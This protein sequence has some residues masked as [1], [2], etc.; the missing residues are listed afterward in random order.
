MKL[1]GGVLR[2]DGGDVLLLALCG[3]VLRDDGGGDVLLLVL[4][5]DGGGDGNL[6]IRKWV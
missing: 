1:R 6:R 5:G 4:C 2:D 3:G